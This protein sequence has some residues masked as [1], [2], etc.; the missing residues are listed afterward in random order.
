MK[1]LFLLITA[2]F[3]TTLAFANHIT[4]GE[5]FYI[6]KGVSGNDYTYHIT[7]RLYRDCYSTGAQLDQSAAI[8]I[9]RKSDNV[10]VM[11]TIAQRTQFTTLNL[12]SPSPCIQN[13]PLVCYEVG[14]YEF[15]ATLPGIP[16]GYI[17]AYQRCCRINGINNLIAS[18]SVGATYTAEI[19]GTGTLASAPANNSAHFIGADT[20][21]VCANNSFCYNF[22][23]VDPDSP[24]LGDSLSYSFCSAYVGGGNGSG[25]GANSPAPNPPSN[26]PYTPAP[27]ALPYSGTSPLGAGVQLDTR[28]GMLCGIAPPAGIYVV[29][30]CVTEYRNGTAIA[31]QRKD[32]QIKIGDCLV[33]DA[34][35]KQQYL[36]CKSFTYTFQNE[37]PSNP[38]VKTYYWDFGDG[39]TSTDATPAHTYADT[40]TYTF[41]LVI[42]RNQDC[43][44]SAI[45][46][47]KVYPGFFPGFTYKG[48]CMNKPTQFTD[49]TKTRYGTVTGWKWDFGDPA[50]N[51]DI[52]SL[53]NPTF[54]YT[55][56]GTNTIRLIATNSIGCVDT[57]FNSITIM[58]KP[59]LSVA[60]K[61]TL[62]CNGDKLQLHA[63]GNGTFSWT[64]AAGITNANT[65]DPTVSPAST[66][67]YFVQLDD[68]GCLNHDSVQ[69]RV[70]NFVTLKAG[71]DT[72]ICAGDSAQ[73]RATGD[74][75]SYS[76]SPAATINNPGN[77][78]PKARTSVATTYK[79]TGTIGHCTATDNVQVNTIPLPVSNA[80]ADTA[81]CYGTPAQLNGST[82][83]SSYSWSPA[84]SLNNPASLNPV[85]TPKST[86]AYVLT[87]LDNRGCPKPVK[88][89]VV[90]TVFPKVN[91]FAGNDTSVVIGQP[92][93]LT[94][95]GGEGYL[96]K[97]NTNLSK[98]DIFNPVGLY[99][100]SFDSIRYTVFV[101]AEN[102]C[103]DSTSVLV[104]IFKTI[105]QVFVPTAFTPNGDGHNDVFRPI[106]VGISKIEYFRVFNRWGELVFSTTTSQKGWDGK[107]NGKD[108]GTN[109]YVWVVKAIDYLGKAFF[110]KGT[111]TLIR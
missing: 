97:P 48:I 80:G 68:N 87:V 72:A 44:D 69:V 40:G 89:T 47:I 61:D 81:I 27:Y 7:L 96:W 1:R 79:V 9:F 75:L 92:L 45:S 56:T 83:A 2:F 4:G 93:Q 67:K 50:S 24:T 94:A 70:V 101:T 25:T 34:E 84:F 32:L 15:D 60:F 43:S 90:V 55:K 41:K 8:A 51:T 78:N 62:I 105:P 66:S 23:A 42:N 106:A 33:A 100:G 30:V 82:D 77:A 46:R 10:M 91:A 20:I 26:P 19:P 28:T 63:T 39:T 99:D 22:G 35:L 13:P 107:I 109:T 6:L 86:T 12:Q 37:A 71:G 52:S 14:S 21:I 31:V 36:T 53:Q 98:E 102:G 38:M 104:K 11:N 54:T 17:V 108:Q 85:A 29:T 49:T 111:V 5:M 74:A 76:W 58:D 16:Q 57:A 18:N 64:P 95:S 73:L 88:D 103:F 59:P 65:P 3:C 110:S